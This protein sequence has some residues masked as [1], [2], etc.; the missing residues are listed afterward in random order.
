MKCNSLVLYGIVCLALLVL[1]IV[2]DAN[3]AKFLGKNQGLSK[4]SDVCPCEFDVFAGLGCDDKGMYQI[5]CI[6]V[7]CARWPH[8]IDHEIDLFCC[9]VVLFV[10]QWTQWI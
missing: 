1:Y 8:D 3:G 4:Q 2:G 9:F 6:C 5:R 10:I 7:V